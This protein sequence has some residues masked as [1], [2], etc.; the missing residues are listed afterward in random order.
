[1][2]FIIILTLS[3]CIELQARQWIVFFAKE[4]FFDGVIRQSFG[5][6]YVAL[7]W[8]DPVLNKK[9]LIDCFGYYPKGGIRSKGLFGF[10]DGEMRDDLASMREHDFAVEITEQ[11]LFSCLILKNIWSEKRYSLRANN[12]ID[13]MRSYCKAISNLKLPEGFFLLPSTYITALRLENK[14]R[15]CREEIKNV[16]E[17]DKKSG[18]FGFI[19]RQQHKISEKFKKIRFEKLKLFSRDSVQGKK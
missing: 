16:I 3:I 13:F 2:I 14:K 1:M 12:C 19:K 10:M 7:V 15:E 17:V 6:A 9:V 5:H 18:K 4:G 8:E 11:E